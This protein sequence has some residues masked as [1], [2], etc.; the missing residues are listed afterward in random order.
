MTNAVRWHF[1][2]NFLPTIPRP[3]HDTSSS[4]ECR[5]RHRRRRRIRSADSMASAGKV[6][7]QKPLGLLAPSAQPLEVLAPLSGLALAL[8]TAAHTLLLATA[9]MAKSLRP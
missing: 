6:S 2:R 9:G 8:M 1:P 3:M 7:V 5:Q 4:D